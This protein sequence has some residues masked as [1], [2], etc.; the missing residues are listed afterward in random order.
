MRERCDY[1]CA[2][3]ESSTSLL[4]AVLYGS[5]IHFELLHK[6][7]FRSFADL[8]QCLSVPLHLQFK[9]PLEM[10]NNLGNGLANDEMQVCEFNIFKYYGLITQSWRGPFES[11]W[12]NG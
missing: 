7:S 2:N 1:F 9:L 4:S 5:K 10:F 12:C 6:N 11:N 8:V 3:L